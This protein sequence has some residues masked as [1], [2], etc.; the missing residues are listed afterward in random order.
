VVNVDGKNDGGTDFISIDKSCSRSYA[1]YQITT[2][3]TD[4][5]RKAYKDAEK[6]ILKLGVN[7]FFFLTTFV[8]NETEARKIENQIT[9]ELN[10]HTTCLSANLIAGLIISDGLL[11]QFL[12][13]TNYP[14]PRDYSS[15]NIDYREIALHSY[16]LLS[17]DASD[18]KEGIYDDTILF[19]LSNNVELNE[20]E[21]IEQVSS[22]LGLNDTKEEILK[23]RV[24]ALFGRERLKRSITGKIEL[25]EKARNDFNSRKRLYEIELANLVSAQ[26]DL[27][28]S[29]YHVDW[30]VEDSKKTSVWIADA[31]ISQQISNLKEIKASIVSHP[32]FRA[33]EHSIDKLKDFLHK[34][35]NI[36]LKS[37]DKLIEDLLKLA[38]NHPLINKITRASIY[39][40]LEGSNPI[41]SAKSLGGN[42]WSDFNIMVEPT[43]AIPYTC[44]H[45]YQ[46]Y[47]N[48]YFD[49]SIKSINR[50]KKLGARL[51]IPFFYIN[52]CAGHLF[53]AR[54]YN[55][56]ELDENE[57][58][59]SSNAFVAN[60]YALKRQGARLPDTFMDYLSSFSPAIRNER[61]DIKNWIRSLM[62]DLQSI[63]SKSSVEFVQV[64]LYNHSDCA[65]FEKEYLYQMSE[66]EIEKPTH[67]VNHD[68]WGLQYTNDRIVKNKEHWIILTYDRSLISFSKTD[69]Y[70]GWVTN[71]S[72]FVDITES[73]KPLSE[74]HFISLLHSVATFSEKTLSVGARIIDRIIRYAS[75]E[76][77][78]WEFKKDIERFKNEVITSINLNSPDYSYEVDKRTDSFLKAKGIDLLNT[79]DTDI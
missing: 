76:M 73:N 33:D 20:K 61:S 13:E 48:R 35:K 37:I 5:T 66:L 44:A 52:E 2:Q 71:P 39:L 32:I 21:I 51:F 47:V 26:T 12:D 29:D 16:T 11:N 46:G 28:R 69:K 68:I 22:F 63:L 25:S 41:S 45:L 56:I 36:D 38:Y 42:R 19:V 40:A 31:F 58:Q 24:G 77:Q 72:K 30:T 49:M 8:L 27:M 43:V 70:Q 60:Y 4:I 15:K 78:N 62:T 53:Q 9:S 79:D 1:A 59:Y 7:R 17:N 75:P 6:S 34:K 54:R 10:I 67:L 55:G 23:R 18:L 65:D 74:T 64:P 14:L 50:A 57:L 3:K